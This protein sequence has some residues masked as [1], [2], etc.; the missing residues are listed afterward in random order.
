MEESSLLHLDDELINLVKKTVKENGSQAH[1][2]RV[3]ETLLR[4]IQEISRNQKVSST[5][6]AAI[7]SGNNTTMQKA[8]SFAN[9]TLERHDHKYYLN[10][11]Q[12]C[13]N[14]IT[15]RGYVT[16]SVTPE[17][18][19]FPIAY[20]LI[21]YTDLEMAERLLRAIYRPQNF[22]CIH[23]DDK[24]SKSYFDA[25]SSIA[26]CFPNVFI[27]SKRINVVWGTFSVLKVELLCMEELWKYTSWKY[28]INLAGQ[29]FPLK[30]NFELVK[31]LKAFNGA[32]SVIGRINKKDEKRWNHVKRLPNVQPIKGSVHIVVNRQFVDFILHNRTSLKILK[33]T[34]KTIIPDETF[35][36]TLNFNPQLN[37]NGSFPGWCCNLNTCKT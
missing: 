34:K 16:S 36:S 2:C 20:S 9:Q 11:T 29:E 3:N 23:V 4:H 5:N 26:K 19:H 30:T 10:L 33:W 28:F 15:S 17:E 37:I 7:F 8:I 1:V 12:S 32:N 24:S 13:Q 22:Y 31:I 21:I 27:A 6:C 25:V 18:D 14:F 35:F